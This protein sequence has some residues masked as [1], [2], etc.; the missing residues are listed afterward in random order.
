MGRVFGRIPV[1]K[2]LIWG[3]YLLAIAGVIYCIAWA[4]DFSNEGFMDLWYSKLLYYISIIG[5]SF[6]FLLIIEATKHMFKDLR[7]LKIKVWHIGVICLFIYII[8]FGLTT[9]WYKRIF[10]AEL[11]LLIVWVV[12]QS[13][14]LI[15]SYYRGFLT[16]GST[17]TLFVLLAI[18]TVLGLIFYNYYYSY[19]GFYQLNLGIYPYG[20]LIVFGTIISIFLQHSKKTSQRFSMDDY[21]YRWYP[22][23]KRNNIWTISIWMTICICCSAVHWLYLLFHTYRGDMIA[24]QYML[25]GIMGLLLFYLP[26][27]LHDPGIFHKDMNTRTVKEGLLGNEVSALIKKV[28][29]KLR[30]KGILTNLYKHQFLISD[31][32]VSQLLVMEAREDDMVILIK[33]VNSWPNPFRKKI[34][35]S[36]SKRNEW[37]GKTFKIVED[38]IPSPKA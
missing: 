28:K 24:C 37:N 6:G 2:A 21:Q 34:V 4:L 18:G 17:I 10:T 19:T 36:W 1:L 8:S 23:F 14:V 11:F 31:I 12:L 29:K 9:V 15:G 38:A 13:A 3:H 25:G 22:D 35:I 20:I 5:T 27:T 32:R 33:E 16:K 7:G 30:K 26:S